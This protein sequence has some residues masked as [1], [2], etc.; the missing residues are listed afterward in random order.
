MS[1][2]EA[3][4]QLAS[5][6]PTPRRTR[7]SCQ[8]VR[9]SPDAAVIMLQN[10]TP[11]ARIR[12][13]FERSARRPSGTPIAAYSRVKAVASQ[14]SWMSSRCHSLRI[15]SASTPPICRSKKLIALIANRTHR[16]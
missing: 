12:T 14:P 3:G 4:A 7:N 11:A 8:K 16:A 1:D 15:G 13:R 9:V 6:T 10:E 2:V 5:P